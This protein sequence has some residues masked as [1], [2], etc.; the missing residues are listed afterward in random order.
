[1]HPEPGPIAAHLRSA[2]DALVK[3]A[4]G[5]PGVHEDNPW[6]HRAFKAKKPVFLF[7]TLDARGL[8]ATVKLPQS[9]AAALDK[10]FCEPTGYGMGAKG[11]VTAQLA[12]EDQVPLALLQAWITESYRA[13]APKT[14]VAQL[15]STPARGAK[16]APKPRR[17][18][19]G[20]AKRPRER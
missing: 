13:V 20:S 2:Q 5:F 1:M 16:P 4:L 14:L 19:R 3:F 11:W 10:S 9:G 8:N 15:D 17:T 18:A 7:L 6:G 12:P